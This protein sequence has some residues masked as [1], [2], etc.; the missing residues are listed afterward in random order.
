MNRLHVLLEIK[1]YFE[2]ESR[3]AKYLDH[4]ESLIDSEIEEKTDSIFDFTGYYLEEGDLSCDIYMVVCDDLG[5]EVGLYQG[6]I[7]AD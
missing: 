1:E 3:Y 7:Y 6:R 2:K 4:L 5:Y